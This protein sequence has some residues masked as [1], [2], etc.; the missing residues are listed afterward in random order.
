VHAIGNANFLFERSQTPHCT[1]KTI[2]ACFGVSSSVVY[3]HSKK[4]RELLQIEPLAKRWTLAAFQQPSADPQL[5]QVNGMT[6]DIRKLPSHAQWQLCGAA[7]ASLGRH[8]R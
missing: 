4:A 1:I 2:Q 6:I 3:A 8:S 5:V 7:L